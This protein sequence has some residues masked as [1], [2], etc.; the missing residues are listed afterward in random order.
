ML[1]RSQARAL[2]A[3]AARMPRVDE[4]ATRELTRE[5]PAEDQAR[6]LRTRDLLGRAGQTSDDARARGSRPRSGHRRAPQRSRAVSGVDAHKPSAVSSLYG[7][8]PPL[9]PAQP[10]RL[11]YEVLTPSQVVL[12]VTG[13]I[14]MAT[15]PA[16]AEALQFGVRTAGSGTDLIADLTAVTFIDARGLAAL[17]EAADTA[18]SSGVV[19]QVTGCS[20]CMLRLLALTG[21]R[22][23]M[24]IR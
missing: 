8:N 3:E 7:G 10:F 16:L 6:R 9:P 21:T 5:A 1:D 4:G 22:D 15:A 12:H 11:R 19:F 2:T 23:L 24:D 13:E 20:P 14:D 17:L 18:R